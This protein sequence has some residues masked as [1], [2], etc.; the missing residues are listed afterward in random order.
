[1]AREGPLELVVIGQ[2]SELVSPGRRIDPDAE[3]F[4]RS[5]PVMSNE[6]AAR[7]H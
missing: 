5:A 7:I 1:M 2:P 3:D 4:S 6:V